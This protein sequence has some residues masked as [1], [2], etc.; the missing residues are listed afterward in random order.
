MN[1]PTLITAWAA[2]ATAIAALLCP[3]LTA[4]ITTRAEYRRRKMELDAEHKSKVVSEFAA[5][6]AGLHWNTGTIPYAKF[7]ASA[8]S[9]L[10]ISKNRKVRQSIAKVIKNLDGIQSTS[11]SDEL[12]QVL[13]TELAEDW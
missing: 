2:M 7:M 8:Y 9:L 11:E 5:S 12:F 4:I 10:S 6:Y 1:D 3:M 13:M